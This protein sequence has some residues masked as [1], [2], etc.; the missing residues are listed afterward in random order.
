VDESSDV[1]DT[2][3]LTF[4]HGCNSDIVITEGLMKWIPTYAWNYKWRRYFLWDSLFKNMDFHLT[5]LSTLWVT[6][7]VM[8][9][10]KNSLVGKMNISVATFV[11]HTPRELVWK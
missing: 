10:I 9:G 5:Y 8:S 6:A 11:Y 1:Q 7:S 2:D 3:H 4:V